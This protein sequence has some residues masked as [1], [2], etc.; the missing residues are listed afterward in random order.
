MPVPQCFAFSGA[1]LCGKVVYQVG[2]VIV[3]G[4]INHSPLGG[5]H[6]DKD[7]IEGEELGR[8]LLPGLRVPIEAPVFAL[9][10]LPNF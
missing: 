7:L 6:I 5:L 8:K 3:M 10:Q 1:T 4:C 9:V 2:S